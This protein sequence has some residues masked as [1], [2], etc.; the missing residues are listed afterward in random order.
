M[1][2]RWQ[3]RAVRG[4]G[5]RGARSRRGAANRRG[6]RGREVVGRRRVIKDVEEVWLS[7]L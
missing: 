3:L 7:W 4:E 1:M 6:G 2:G 5:R